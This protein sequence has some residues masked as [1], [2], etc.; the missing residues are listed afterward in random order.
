MLNE[1]ISPVICTIQPMKFYRQNGE[2]NTLRSTDVENA[3]TLNVILTTGKSN[4]H[5][6]PA[7]Y[8]YFCHLITLIYCLYNVIAICKCSW[9]WVRLKFA[10]K[11]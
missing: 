7:E 3:L 10:A 4:Q 5:L 11:Y 2:W 6:V 9:L 1:I 8:Y